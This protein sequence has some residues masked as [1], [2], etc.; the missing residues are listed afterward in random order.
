[1]A[2]PTRNYINS[3][4]RE[5]FNRQF[6]YGYHIE[7]E[8]KNMRNI[9]HPSYSPPPLTPR[10]NNNRSTK[11]QF[12]SKNNNNVND[13]KNLFL[14]EIMDQV[15][16]NIST[17]LTEIIKDPTLNQ[18]QI[19]SLQTLIKTLKNKESI[20]HNILKLHFLYI[21]SSNIFQDVSIGL[22]TTLNEYN[23]KVT[24]ETK[25]LVRQLPRNIT[26][27]KKINNLTRKSLP[28]IN[29]LYE[30]AIN[31]E[32][33]NEFKTI[34]INNGSGAA[35]EFNNKNRVYR[36]KIEKIIHSLETR[37]KT[38][39]N[40]DDITLQNYYRLYSNKLK[41]KLSQLIHK[42]NEKKVEMINYALQEVDKS[43]ERMI[44]KYERTRR[45][46]AKRRAELIEQGEPASISATV[47]LIFDNLIRDATKFLYN[48]SSKLK[49]NISKKVKN[50]NINTK[51]LKALNNYETF[52]YKTEKSYFNASGLSLFFSE[53][54][55]I[56][57]NAL[58]LF[59]IIIDII[60]QSG[61]LRMGIPS[62][63]KEILNNITSKQNTLKR[64]SSTTNNTRITNNRLLAARRKF[65]RKTKRN[66]NISRNIKKTKRKRNNNQNRNAKKSRRANGSIN[67]E[68]R[69]ET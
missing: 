16:R 40:P 21:L 20:Y 31:E 10:N 69:M 3:L 56:I 51:K 37:L 24:E 18:Q 47:L 66:N 58:I 52:Y 44:D 1:M 15:L 11:K 48:K 53:N 8:E 43:R 46:Y 64:S 4:T 32:L 29:N 42:T 2:A 28:N 60:N 68:S 41:L 19:N 50:A 57:H 49:Q 25:Q 55:N 6:P 65:E 9:P 59:P 17:R 54:P 27:Y 5:E 23:V 14:N 35:E 7:E 30:S 38:T 61:E 22:K 34:L 33:E 63:L 62:Y 12:R 26:P 13:V 36:E 45:E 39:Y 67:N